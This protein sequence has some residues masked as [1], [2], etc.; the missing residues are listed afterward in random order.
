MNLEHA[1]STAQLMI[2]LAAIAFVV[3]IMIF[4]RGINLKFGRAE[5]RLNTLDN[6]ADKIKT[7]AESTDKQLNGRKPEDTTVSADVTYIRQTIDDMRD[8]L[9]QHHGAVIEIR[10]A[11]AAA[12]ADASVVKDVVLKQ[13]SVIAEHQAHIA[14]LAGTLSAHAM[15]LD[16][17]HKQINNH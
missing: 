13:V 5:L 10:T 7:K 2:A 14:S 3:G 1:N 8:T 6:K 16:A 12:A 9:N 4:G 17:H 15:Q 11:A